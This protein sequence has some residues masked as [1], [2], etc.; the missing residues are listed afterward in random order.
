[1]HGRA[2]I[3]G[4]GISGLATG[5]ALIDRGWAVEIH[6][7]SLGLP[8]SGTALVM[9]PEALDALDAVG[10]R[11]LVE[12][13]AHRQA[14]MRVLRPDGSQIAAIGARRPV[15]AISRPALLRVL[16]ENLPG[17]VVRWGST[18]T[19]D[20]ATRP[21]DLVVGADGINSV[22]RAS[23]AGSSNARP[24]PLDTVA[25][26]GTV[27]R[28][29]QDTS[30]TWGDGALFGVSALDAETT[31]W[32]ASVR[33][34]VLRDHDHGQPSIELLRDLFRRWHPAVQEVLECVPATGID[35][36]TLYDLPALPSYVRG[37]VALVG[38]AAHAMAPNL[39][40]GA[41]ESL[42]DAVALGKA[43]GDAASLEA[44]L[45]RY[46][47]TRRSSS[48]RIVALSRRM[49]RLSTA[50]RFVGARNAFIRAAAH[51]A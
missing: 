21:V 34:E 31:N 18:L 50:R 42:I 13:H 45:R 12:E 19:G 25:F 6:E 10:L 46:D 15:Q 43:M 9:W 11:T 28:D 39:G 40:R 8:Q 38:D 3:I 2:V 48:R 4:G 37:N 5:S 30:E 33:V 23:A 47:E 51:F 24:R 36:R 32:Y 22:L 26:R 20:D 7:R 17:G 1:M 27:A 16:H 14:G 41:C 29:T 49:S 44:G 35:R